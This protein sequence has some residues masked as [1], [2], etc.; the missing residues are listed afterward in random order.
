MDRQKIEEKFIAG[1]V[2]REFSDY[3][4]LVITVRVVYM[5]LGIWALYKS[6]QGVPMGERLI[7]YA[8]L[9]FALWRI[10]RQ[11]QPVL[12]L[13]EKGI[14]VRRRPVDMVER[15]EAFWDDDPYFFFADYT[16]VMGFTERWENLHIGIPEEG[17][18]LIVPVDLQYLRYRD[19]VFIE[20]YIDA[21]QHGRFDAFG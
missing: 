15:L 5:C 20:E 3:S 11:G 4:L 16:Q 14:V 12:F 21:Q 7:D 13:C 18:I 10:C 17:G 19:K 2:V 1:N 9:L 8:I 6:M